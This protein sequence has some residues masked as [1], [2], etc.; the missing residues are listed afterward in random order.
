VNALKTLGVFGLAGLALI[1][2]YVV[3]AN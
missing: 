1:L 3:S 2:L